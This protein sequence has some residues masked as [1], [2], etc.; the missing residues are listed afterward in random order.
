MKV[1]RTVCLSVYVLKP[2][3]PLDFNLRIEAVN[4]FNK[5]PEA[6]SLAIANKRV[7]N[8]LKKQ[9]HDDIK[10]PCNKALLNHDSEKNL[11]TEIKNKRLEMSPLIEEFN[12]T[13]ALLS[14]SSL[15]P[16][17]DDFFD[18][19]LVIDENQKLRENRLSLLSE[20][21]E[22]FLMTADI[23]FLDPSS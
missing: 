21:R 7:S 5:L 13:E 2:E 18:N 23:S 19:V 17:V 12:Y 4:A 14:L 20:L 6:M 16:M 15:K 11:F 10:S 1:Y 9:L 8:L 22:L 3:R